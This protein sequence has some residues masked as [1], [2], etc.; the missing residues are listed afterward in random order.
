M[1]PSAQPGMEDCR[2]LGVMEPTDQGARLV[3]LNQILP[4]TREVEEMAAPAQ[5]AEIFRFAARCESSKCTHFDGTDCRLAARV[6][7]I[8]PAVVDALPPCLIRPECRWFA[9]EGAH[10]CHRCPQVATVNYNADSVLQEV[11]GTGPVKGPIAW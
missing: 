3:Y 6:V 10:A 7:Q 5:P 2:V 11:S 9:Q 8:L 1:C 4:A